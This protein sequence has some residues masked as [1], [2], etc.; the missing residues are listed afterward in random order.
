MSEP[1]SLKVPKWP[2]FLGDAL[3]L[4][5]AL[6]VYAQAAK[7][8]ALWEMCVMA[9]CIAAA[10]VCGMLPYILEYRGNVKLSA[11]DALQ[12]A[13]TGI[14]KLEDVGSRI[15]SAT[16]HWQM[17][18]DASEKT[19]SDARQISERMTAEAK[20]FGEFIER[21]NDT[22]K[23]NLRLEVDKLRRAEADWLQ[24]LVRM[25]DHVYAL[26]QGAIRSG[27]QS[28]IQQL[29][30]FHHACR[31]VARRVGLV[32]FVAAPDEKFNPERHHLP[33]PKE[34]P[35]PDA[36]VE[37]NLATGYTFQGRMLRPALVRLRQNGSAPSAGANP[38]PE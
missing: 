27:Q 23:A 28:V 16:G 5:T 22:E 15:Q 6:A 32:P 9:G 19:V 7:P 2:F 13:L 36:V 18:Q 8:L 24:V 10:A 30:R 29:D 12:S 11:T 35:G 34:T 1:V 17:V 31:E 37:E 26:H 25:L 33:D 20:A 14:Q 38:P 21:A 4:G 3:L